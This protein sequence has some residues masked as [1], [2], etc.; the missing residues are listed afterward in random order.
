[1]HSEFGLL[2]RQQVSFSNDLRGFLPRT[3]RLKAIADYG[4]GR[5]AEVTSE[6]AEE[7]IDAAVR[8]IAAIVRD[9]ESP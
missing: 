5:D 7:A 1:M 8:L 9:L 6:E 3:Y 2:A 4:V